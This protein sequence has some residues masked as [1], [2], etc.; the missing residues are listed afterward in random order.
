V[1]RLPLAALR[2]ALARAAAL[3]RKAGPGLRVLTYHRVND[4]HPRDRLS[5]PPRSFAAQM[6][7]LADSGRPVVALGDALPALRGEAALPPRAVALTFDDGY[8]DNHAEALPALDRHGFKACFFIVTGAVGTTATIERYAAC[9]GA[10]RMLDWDEVRELQARGH[11]IG[12]HGRRHRELASLTADEVRDEV[13]GSLRDIE[14]RIGERPRLFCYPRGSVDAAARRI[15][16]EAGFEA[17]CTVRPGPNAPGADLLTLRRTE[18]AGDDTLE[19]FLFKLDGGFDAWHALAQRA[20]GR[21]R[22]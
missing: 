2:R 14:E 17:A 19:D 16:G 18:V 5:V 22:G 21:R 9:C 15:V 11:A 3:G 7:G 20:S 4:E 13:G 8:A 1:T 10:D 12:G 6:Q